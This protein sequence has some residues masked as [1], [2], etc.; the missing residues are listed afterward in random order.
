MP[1][2]AEYQN[3]NYRLRDELEEAQMK[4][5]IAE[6]QI[7]SISRVIENLATS[8]S[9][10]EAEISACTEIVSGL[11]QSASEAPIPF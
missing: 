6:T 11:L 2:K 7:E 10:T 5:A 4:I 1:T 8:Q 9:K 3:E